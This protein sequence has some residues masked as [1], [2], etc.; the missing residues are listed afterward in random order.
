RLQK[1]LEDTRPQVWEIQDRLRILQEKGCCRERPGQPVP[2][3]QLLIRWMELH[4]RLQQKIQSTQKIRKNYERFQCN[5]TEL[6][7]WICRAQEQVQKWNSLS[8]SDPLNSRTILTQLTEFFK[9]LE[10][11]S[12]QK[13]SAECAGTQ[14]LQLTDNEA[15]GL[16]RRLAQ[17]EQEWMNL[18]SELPTLS[19]TQ[20]Q[21]RL[22]C[23]S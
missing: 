8:D 17:L 14:I 11:R 23:L 22:M 12:A 15:P 16:R 2:K 9:E 4:N 19:Q 1:V 3:S 6:E 21:V 18:T 5:S 20:Q 7:V 13:A 10:V